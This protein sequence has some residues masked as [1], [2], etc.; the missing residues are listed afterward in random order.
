MD[1]GLQQKPRA[2][3]LLKKNVQGALQP[4]CARKDCFLKS[5][6]GAQEARTKTDR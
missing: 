4:M 1:Q 2:L 3:T 6:L 5:S